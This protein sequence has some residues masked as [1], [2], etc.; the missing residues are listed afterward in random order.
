[1]GIK[2]VFFCL[3]CEFFLVKNEKEKLDGKEKVKKSQK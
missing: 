1:M 3:L 2:I